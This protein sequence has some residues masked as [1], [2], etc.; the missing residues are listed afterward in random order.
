MGF[1][2]IATID[3]SRR[4]MLSKFFADVYRWKT[5]DKVEMWDKGG[6]LLIKLHRPNTKPCCILC[7]EPT[8]RL[9]IDF[10]ETCGTC[11]SEIDF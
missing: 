2:E 3:D 11:L 1:I 5:G 6:A 8:H 10:A 7:G 9:M 4:I